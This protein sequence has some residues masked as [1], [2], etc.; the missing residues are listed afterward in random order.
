MDKNEIE[1]LYK[2][3]SEAVCLVKDK[4][5]ISV[6]VSDDDGYDF[7]AF[8]K[9][10][11]EEH[12]VFVDSGVVEGSRCAMGAVHDV[13]MQC[14]SFLEDPRQQDLT[15]EDIQVLSLL[16]YQV[17]SFDELLNWIDK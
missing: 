5:V 16:A 4:Y 2:E 7:V 13:Y 17:E 10:N 15:N 1:Y 9:N 6:N 3:D 8:C 12:Y 14:F 11:D